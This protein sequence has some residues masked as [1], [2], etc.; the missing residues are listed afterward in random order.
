ML[1]IF[2]LIFIS[3]LFVKTVEMK[4]KLAKSFTFFV[5]TRLFCSVFAE[6]RLGILSKERVCKSL[7]RKNGKEYTHYYVKLPQRNVTRQFANSTSVGTSRRERNIS[8]PKK[9]RNS[10]GLAYGSLAT[11][12]LWKELGN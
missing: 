6:E 2:H 8:R 5:E 3:E 12:Q 11:K 9:S 4:R 10:F 7:L 1:E